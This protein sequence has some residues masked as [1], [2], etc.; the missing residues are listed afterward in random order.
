MITEP[1]YVTGERILIGDVV[2]IG[3]WEGTVEEIVLEGCPLWDEY[4]KDVTGEGVMLVGPKF[5]RLF[6]RFDD[7]EL[8]LVHRREQ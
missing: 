7:E 8:I 1:K 2:T 3:N 5:G 4:W 6:N